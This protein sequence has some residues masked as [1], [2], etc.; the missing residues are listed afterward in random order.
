MLTLLGALLLTLISAAFVWQHKPVAATSEHTWS[1]ASA[2]YFLS[3]LIGACFGFLTLNSPEQPN[4]LSLMFE[5]L[6]FYA[7]LPLLVCLEFCRFFNVNGSRQTW[8]R[9]LLG[10]AA[11]FELCRRADVLSEMLWITLILGSC[12]LL[13][14]VW[15]KPRVKGIPLTLL[16][17]MLWLVASAELYAQYLALPNIMMLALLLAAV[18]TVSPQPS[19]TLPSTS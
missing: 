15:K 9:I 1:G 3:G 14:T 10:I 6:S 12:A 4:T 13:L 18:W 5:Q 17:S 16:Q 7:V 2:A 8:G 11:T 19:E